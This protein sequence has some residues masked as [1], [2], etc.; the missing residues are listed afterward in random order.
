M[1]KE[2]RGE[3]REKRG[4]EERRGEERR[5]EERRGEERKRGEEERGGEE[6]PRGGK[7]KGGEET[8]ERRGTRGA[9]SL[10]MCPYSK[11]SPFVSY[12]VQWL[13]PDQTQKNVHCQK[14]EGKNL[15]PTRHLEERRNGG[16]EGKRRRRK[17]WRDEDTKGN[18]RRGR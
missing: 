12:K 18:D 9:N 8:E 10:R 4:R 16:L 2:R 14:G 11:N 1:R 5:G 3:K 17:E 15:Q 7:E 6:G 13:K